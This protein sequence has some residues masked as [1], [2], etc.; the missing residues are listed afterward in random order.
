MIYV[1][2]GSNDYCPGL[3]LRKNDFYFV[4]NN[5]SLAKLLKRDEILANKIKAQIKYWS[6]A[7]EILNQL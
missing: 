4:R 3:T 1:G 7:S 6:Q 2:D 5:Y